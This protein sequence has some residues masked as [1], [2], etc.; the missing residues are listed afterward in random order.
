MEKMHG[1][2]HC[3]M[4]KSMI[5]QTLHW[6][7][8]LCWEKRSL[9]FHHWDPNPKL[10]CEII[11]IPRKIMVQP[12]SARRNPHKN[13]GFNQLHPPIWLKSTRLRPPGRARRHPK[14]PARRLEMAD[15]AKGGGVR[16][17]GRVSPWENRWE[18]DG[19][20]MR[21]SPGFNADI[22]CDHLIWENDI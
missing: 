5:P 8:Y 3:L 7:S 17:D 13:H 10:V 21:I 9:M 22:W 1:K 11:E 20:V 15:A 16:R 12:G 2:P 18:I 4:F 6:R 19:K 14:A